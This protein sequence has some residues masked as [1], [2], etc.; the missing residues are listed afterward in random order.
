[1][2][3]SGGGSAGGGEYGDAGYGGQ[4]DAEQEA[5]AGFQ[6]LHDQGVIDLDGP[7]RQMIDVV[8]KRFRERF[9]EEREEEDELEG[10]GY[11]IFGSSGPIHHPPRR[12]RR[13]VSLE[14]TRREAIEQR[15]GQ[16]QDAGMVD[17]D[18]PLR[19]AIPE[20]ARNMVK[21]RSSDSW[22][23]IASGDDPHAV[24]EC[25]STETPE[26]PTA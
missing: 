14:G 21:Y 18:A 25:P 13:I 16:L 10:D 2:A 24:C 1:M 22:W 5:L 4:G 12:P 15:V 20:L 19:D 3:E 17:L 7:A 23:I 8:E 26:S 9:D 6:E 11:W